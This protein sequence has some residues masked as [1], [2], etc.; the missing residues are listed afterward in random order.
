MIDKDP[1][2]CWL[3]EFYRG[4]NQDEKW[5]CEEKNCE[6]SPTNPREI[7]FWNKKNFSLYHL[8]K[9]LLD[10]L[11]FC[12]ICRHNQPTKQIDYRCEYQYLCD[13]FPQSKKEVV[14]LPDPSN[15]P[16]EILM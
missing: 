9:V 11:P 4:Q 12:A 2:L 1:W 16:S 7:Y 6:L 14:P 3:C 8:C 13:E 10:K 15:I 5:K